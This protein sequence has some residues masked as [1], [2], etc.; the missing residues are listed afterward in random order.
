MPV[1]KRL[2]IRSKVAVVWIS[3]TGRW[4]REFPPAGPGVLNPASLR[5]YPGQMGSGVHSGE[6]V[7]FNPRSVNRR[8]SAHE[9][10]VGVQG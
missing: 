5:L 6:K 10:L 2:I 3:E 4:T 8:F 7:F 9:I 1:E